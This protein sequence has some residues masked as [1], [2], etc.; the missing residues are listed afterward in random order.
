MSGQGRFYIV[1]SGETRSTAQSRSVGEPSYMYFV[2][3]GRPAG[4][5]PR[6]SSGSMETTRPPAPADRKLN[7]S[8]DLGLGLDLLARTDGCCCGFEGYEQ[9]RMMYMYRRLHASSVVWVRVSVVWVRVSVSVFALHPPRSTCAAH[10]SG[11]ALNFE[12]RRKSNNRA[13]V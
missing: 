5:A 8:S 12:S 10:P 1:Y 13:A 9:A 2:L 6:R 7:R 4:R 11:Q 3:I